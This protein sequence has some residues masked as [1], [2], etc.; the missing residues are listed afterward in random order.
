MRRLLLAVGLVAGCA[1][2]VTS[3]PAWPKRSEPAS[4]GGESIAPRESRPVEAAIEKAD[5]EP[6]PA[7]APVTAPA[8]V[9]P[10]KDLGAAPAV[11]PPAGPVEETITTEDIVIEVD[12]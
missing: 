5:D 1:S 6:K 8:A 2:H 3:G 7:A 11:A 9:T 10:T 4:D 12:D